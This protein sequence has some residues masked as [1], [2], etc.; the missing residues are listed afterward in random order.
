MLAFVCLC[1]STYP[2][3]ALNLEQFSCFC[4]TNARVTS[5]CHY[6][7][8]RLLESSLVS[9][10]VSCPLYICI[11]VVRTAGPGTIVRK[12]PLLLSSLPHTKGQ[13]PICMP[14]PLQ[15]PNLRS[16]WASAFYTQHVVFTLQQTKR[17]P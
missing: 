13:I 7:W 2:R 17:G 10:S 15:F 11:K 5:M 4:L 14:L 16:P 8:Q 9:L 1:L 3:L 12:P 6:A